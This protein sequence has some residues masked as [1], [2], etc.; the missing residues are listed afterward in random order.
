MKVNPI[1]T[2]RITLNGSKPPIWR[3]VAV[4]SDITLGQLHEVIEIAMGW[5]NSHL[6]QFMLRNKSLKPSRDE[7]RQAIEADDWSD[8]LMGRM[9]GERVFTMLTTPFG[10]PTE[11]EGED[12]DAVTLAEVCSKV[13]SKLTYEYVRRRV[14][15]HH[16]GAEERSRSRAW[17]IRCA[18][19]GSWPARLKTVVVSMVITTYSTQSLI[20]ITKNT[21]T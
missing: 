16:R 20:L 2:I 9:R 18:W 14:G 7:I 12:E 13:K 3:R 21:V 19:P 10:D 17:S 5:T 11:M 4:P 8:E 15:A 1:Y 6:H